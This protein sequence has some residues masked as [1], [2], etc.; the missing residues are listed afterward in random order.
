MA[1]PQ[2]VAQTKKPSNQINLK[3]GE[4]LFRQG[5]PSPDF[6]VLVSGKVEILVVVET[7]SPTPEQIEKDARRV[8]VLDEPK[9]PIGELGALSG[10]PRGATIRALSPAV[11][12]RMKASGNS[13]QKWLTS[14]RVAGLTLARSLTTRFKRTA[15]RWRTL[16]AIEHQVNCI[17]ENFNTA[18]MGLKEEII[19][20]AAARSGGI[21]GEKI[22]AILVRE[23]G[24]DEDAKRE[25]MTQVDEGLGKFFSHLLTAP[26][27]DLLWLTEGDSEPMLFMLTR[28]AESF[29]ILNSATRDAVRVC[30]FSLQ[31]LA[32]RS[33]SIVKR[34]TDIQKELGAEKKQ[35]ILPLLRRLLSIGREMNDVVLDLWGAPLAGF[36]EQIE[37]FEKAMGET[38]AEKHSIDDV[39]QSAAESAPV[40]V[41]EEVVE[42]IPVLDVALAIPT[43]PKE[44]VETFRTCIADLSDDKIYKKATSTFWKIYPHVFRAYLREPKREWVLFLRYGIA[45]PGGLPSDKLSIFSPEIRKPG[46]IQFA[47]EWLKRIYSGETPPSRNEL[48]QSF[49]EV[50]KASE[51]GRYRK[52][53]TDAQ[54]DIVLYEIDNVL[55]PAARGM[56]GGKATATPFISDPG[57]LD[58]FAS[59]CLSAGNI[60]ANLIDILKIDFS[61]F[62]RE[63][64]VVLGEKSD[65]V[66]KD[67]LPNFIIIPAI[68][69]R[70]L[71]WQEWEGKSKGTSGRII[72][73]TQRSGIELVDLLVSAVGAFRWELNYSIAGPSAN[74]PI[75]GGMTGAYG[76]YV[77]FYKKNSELSDEWK[78]KLKKLWAKAGTNRDKFV[79]E[80]IL[81][82]KYEVNGLQK[83]SK[84][85]RR[86]FIEHLPLPVE[87]RKKLLSA[88]AFANILP[89]D[90]NKRTKKRRDIIGKMK[91]LKADG[92]DYG[93]HFKPTLRVYE[94]LPKEE[95]P[96]PQ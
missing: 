64:R 51:T 96:P 5:E 76:D 3:P 9:V 35:E 33:D 53:E 57:K 86:I 27:D 14:N 55:V 94:P 44:L 24:D 46:P 56:A 85:C 28:L 90:S 92:I 8:A 2:P 60:A 7:K 66:L 23:F 4:I 54:F 65:F 26:D 52:D 16:R 81:W 19:S 34:F 47:D 71:A 20:K 77:Q 68:G 87:T 21:S 78:E 59:N 11:L 93:D 36:V 72:L 79:A 74:D 30:E 95:A 32:G 38:P 58:L 62:Y 67:I 80:Y 18:Y 22:P 25:E 12:V 48:G 69:E 43:I 37:T 40:L 41:A 10:D 49:E 31:G 15:D 39:A 75:Q 84:V 6:Y 61:A 17:T 50:I 83:L 91:K 63:V 73:P 70:A 45:L 82:I 29:P 1:D 13:F 42:L 88:P 89:V